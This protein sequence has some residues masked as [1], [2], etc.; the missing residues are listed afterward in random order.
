MD[1][2]RGTGDRRGGP[3]QRRAKAGEGGRP[4]EEGATAEPWRATDIAERE[5]RL[6]RAGGFFRSHKRAPDKRGMGGAQQKSAG[7]AQGPVKI[8]EPIHIKE[9]SAATGVKASVA[10]SKISAST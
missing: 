10:G 5:N 7:P 9:L 1:R 4:R 8:A 2:G 6:N 3:P